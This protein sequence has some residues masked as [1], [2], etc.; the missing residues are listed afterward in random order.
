LVLRVKGVGKGSTLERREAAGVVGAICA[1]VGKGSAEVG[2]EAQAVKRVDQ[3][4]KA[5]SKQIFIFITSILRKKWVSAG[6][7]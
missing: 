5:I 6:R 3:A 4:D 7:I 1:T 2:V